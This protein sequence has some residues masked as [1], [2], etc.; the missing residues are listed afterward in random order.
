MDVAL[1]AKDSSGAA[2][3]ALGLS[4]VFGAVSTVFPSIIVSS[5]ESS[6]PFVVCLIAGG[7]FGAFVGFAYGVMLCIVAAITWA[8]LPLA[9]LTWV[10]HVPSEQAISVPFG[11]FAIGVTL[12][13]AVGSF[14]VV[15]RRIVRRRRWLAEVASGQD[16]RWGIREIDPRDDLGSVPR[17]R[18]GATVLEH[19]N[20]HAIYRATATGEAVAII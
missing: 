18:E 20:E 1:A 9:F 15:Q 17:L 12:S 14:F 11:L 2:G 13:V 4:I 19:K 10:S 3:R 6:V 8:I 5:G 16:P 7:I